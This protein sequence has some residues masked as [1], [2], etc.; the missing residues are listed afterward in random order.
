MFVIAMT[1]AVLAS[2]GMYALA[3]A[4]SEVRTAG[5]ERQNTQTHYLASFGILGATHELTSSR[6]ELYK[7]LMISNPDT[8]LSLPGVLPTADALVKACRRISA[9][10]LGAPWAVKPPIDAYG[11]Q[12]PFAVGVTPGS[13]GPMPMSGDFYIELTNPVQLSAARRYSIDLNFCFL[14][15]T[16]TATGI[17]QPLFPWQKTADTSAQF[18]GEGTEM[19]RARLIAGPVRC[20]K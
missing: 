15:L 12:T 3:A 19:Q 20:P 7:N 5:N 8:C 16:A 2:V 18:A 1:I 10:E 14:Q 9:A 11:G 6:A 17:T 4:S 13:L